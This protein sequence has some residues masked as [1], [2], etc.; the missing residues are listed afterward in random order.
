VN[1]LYFLRAEA[2]ALTSA[3]AYAGTSAIQYTAEFYLSDA[4]FANGFE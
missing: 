4:I 1:R 3:Y 2:T